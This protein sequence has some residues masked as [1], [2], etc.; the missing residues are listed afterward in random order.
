M[1]QISLFSEHKH[2]DN[3]SMNERLQSLG[4]IT[5]EL[6]GVIFLKYNDSMIVRPMVNSCIY[7]VKEKFGIEI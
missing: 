2:I 6:P 1:K 7:V 4:I 5:V 3:R